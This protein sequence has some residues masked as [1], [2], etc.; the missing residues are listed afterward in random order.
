MASN[1]TSADV[2]SL[3]EKWKPSLPFSRDLTDQNENQRVLD[4]ATQILN[5]GLPI[6]DFKDA[7]YG[8]DG[9]DAASPVLVSAIQSAE[10]KLKMK[11][12]GSFHMACVFAMYME[13]NRIQTKDVHKNGQD[14]IR[15]KHK[16]L[17]WLFDGAEG[18]TW[19]MMA[20]DDG[21]PND[22]KSL[23]RAIVEKEGYKNVRVLDLEDQVK[24]QTPFFIDRGLKA[25]CKDSRK[26]GAILYGLK[27]AAEEGAAADPAGPTRLVMYTDSDLSSDMSLCGYLAHGVMVEG[28]GMSMGARYGEEGTFLVKPPTHGAS[29]HP[30][31]HYEQPNMMKIVFRQYVRSRLLPML[32]GIKDTQCA[33]KCFRAGGAKEGS[34]G[35]NLMQVL[36]EVR[37]MQADFDMEL[38]L[39]VLGYLRK[40]KAGDGGDSVKKLC[41]VIPTLFTEDFAES[42]F[43]GGADS[44]ADKPFKTYN[45]MNKALIG[46]HERHVPEG[47]EERKKVADLVE[48]LKNLEWE[49]YKEIILTLEK[50]LGHTLFDFDLKLPDESLLKH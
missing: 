21:C 11:E 7:S 47:S 37:S 30:I 20:V 2:N 1:S 26:G 32:E 4:L 17:A 31:S 24:A 12:C 19:E 13:Q 6:Q 38:L 50:N 44:D 28:G 3:I 34:V 48:Y 45:Q 49:R 23:A 39:C 33:F 14:F 40:V 41:V 42:N 29:G 5:S 18:Q 15:M 46:M 36:N 9:K 43:M 25:G 10:S 22:S 8:V 27:T 16:Q 35:G